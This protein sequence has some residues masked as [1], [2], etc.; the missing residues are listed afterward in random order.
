MLTN[1]GFETGDFS[2]WSVTIPTGTS[3]ACELRPAGT[4]GV[5]SS[6]VGGSSGNINILPH[7]GNSFASIGSAANAGF[8][9]VG[10]IYDITACRNLTLRE[11]E[12]VS[13]WA[14]FYNGDF[15]AQE[16]ASVRVFD[17][18]GQLLSMPWSDTSG[19]FSDG[20]V[21]L[22]NAS[23]WTFWEWQ[24]PADG[25]YSLKLGVT[26]RGDDVYATFGMFDDITVN[27]VPEP[28]VALLGLVG[29][30]LLFAVGRRNRR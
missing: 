16:T 2:L 13:G 12:S 11:G 9:N 5:V 28:S 22:R 1:G 7:G 26:T 30:G 27:P 6:F 14:L 18:T 17:N 21:P 3:G 15:E 4:A 19:F 25:D 29:F 20:G 24:A 23:D 10:G 8:T